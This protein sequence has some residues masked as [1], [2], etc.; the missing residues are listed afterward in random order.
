MSVGSPLTYTQLI[1]SSSTDG[2]IAN[3]LNH[4]SIVNSADTI[5]AEA[6]AWIYRDLRHWRMLTSTTGAFTANIGGTTTVVD[7]IALPGDYLED[8]LLY[9]TGIY[10]SRMVRKTLEEVISLYGYDGNGNRIVQQPY[11]YYNDQT[12]LKFDS[13]PDQAYPYLLYYYQ[14]PASLA[15]VNGGVN[16]LTQFYPRLLRC[17][18]CMMAA[19]FMK[20][21][22]QGNYDRTYWMTQASGELAKAQ[23]ES[24]RAQRAQDIGMILN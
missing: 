6:E 22:G 14:Q 12:N 9:I 13:A 11:Y 19:E 18:C 7:Y 8:K 23:V 2:S 21:A 5:V 15:T 17:A 1:G 3:W 4:A 10:F 16:F 24:D 20:D